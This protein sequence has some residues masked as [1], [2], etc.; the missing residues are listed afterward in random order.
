MTRQQFI[1]ETNHD[2]AQYSPAAVAE[3]LN[4]VVRPLAL[5]L[6]LWLKRRRVALR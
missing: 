4:T 6:A 5:G 3:S 1:N 2:S